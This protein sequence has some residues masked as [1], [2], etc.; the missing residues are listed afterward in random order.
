MLSWINR[1]L[2][3]T[4]VPILLILAGLF[5]GIRLKFFHLTRG[6][7]ILRA[8]WTKDSSADGV[9]PMRALSLA[10]AGT[11]GVGNIVGVSAAIAVGGF[12]AIFWMWVSALCAMLLKYAEIVLAMR[13]R[14]WDSEGKPHGGAFYYIRDG[15]RERG[16]P[17]IGVFLASV[18]ALFCI[19]NSVTMGSVI[20]VSAVTHAFDGV[21]HISPLFTGCAL[22]LFTFLTIRRGSER[23]IALTGKLVPLMTL[24]YL[25]LSAAVL[26]LRVDGL[27]DA[28][29]L[30]FEDAFRTNAAVGGIGG[31]LLSDG[32]RLGTMRG[33][34][35]NEA[36]C[37][38][39]PTAHAVSS[40]PSP[41]R[42][43]VWGIF[44][45]FADTILLCTVTALVIILGWRD[46]A[47][48]GEDYMMM[49]VRAYASALGAPAAYFMAIAVLF[50]GFATIV[51]WGHYGMESVATLTKRP[52]ARRGFIFL[53][54]S[55]VFVGAFATSELIWDLADFAVGAMCLL[56]VAVICMMSGEVREE[57][58]LWLREEREDRRRRKKTS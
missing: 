26:I 28:F 40:C 37:G 50:F 34:V 1:Y 15:L 21:F 4:T 20:Q 35:S 32:V 27:G 3:G 5:Y 2:L 55:S 9:S 46:A 10:L 33:L 8:L 56:N 43:G 57:T 42:Q 11:L 36:G 13:H 16:F 38:T 30:I 17:V 7:A 19:M 25:I 14:R 58:E 48:A 49:T 22:A 24:G 18:F 23:V 6:G 45:V 54:V 41:A 31:F 29:R 39:A 44:E 12:G 52:V 47:G 53:Y 51:C